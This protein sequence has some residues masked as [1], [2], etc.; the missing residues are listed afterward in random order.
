M[1]VSLHLAAAL[2]LNVT[3]MPLLSSTTFTRA[4]ERSGMGTFA[5]ISA[6]VLTTRIQTGGQSFF[7]PSPAFC[8]PASAGNS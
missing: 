6:N 2:Q 1:K 7:Q 3:E 8:S 4:N 5:T